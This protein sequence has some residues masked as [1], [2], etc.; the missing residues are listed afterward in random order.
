MKGLK[1]F[2]AGTVLSASFLMA[3]SAQAMPIPQYDAMTASQKG[4]YDVFLIEGAANYLASQGDNAGAAKVRGLLEIDPGQATKPAMQQFIAN[5]NGT[6]QLN[7]QHASDPGFKPF[8]VEHALA[9]TLKQNG[10][11]VPVSKLL[12]VGQTYKPSQPSGAL[13]ARNTAPQ[14]PAPAA[15]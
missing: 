1:G 12:Q 2:I 5:I 13:T 3:G 8:E 10:I 11:V 4:A 7:Q 6:R 15:R 14:A 9:L